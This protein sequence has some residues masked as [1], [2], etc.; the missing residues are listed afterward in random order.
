MTLL[1]R[2]RVDAPLGCLPTAVLEPGCANGD[3]GS[4]RSAGLSRFLT[5]AGKG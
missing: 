5:S 2:V 4:G 1:A 3:A